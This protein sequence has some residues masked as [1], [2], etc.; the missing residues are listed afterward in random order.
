[1]SMLPTWPLTNLSTNTIDENTQKSIANA[2]YMAINQS[3]EK[4]IK[5]AVDN[6]VDNAMEKTISK[7]IE[8]KTSENAVECSMNMEKPQERLVA[9]ENLVKGFLEKEKPQKDVVIASGSILS[10]KPSGVASLDATSTNMN[11]GVK[12]RG[13][14]RNL[15][16]II[17]GI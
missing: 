3:I 4:A 16:P 9:V 17:T 7:A 12:T 8:F 10:C 14:R 6:A 2:A 11:E 5:N 1:M 15:L 13:L